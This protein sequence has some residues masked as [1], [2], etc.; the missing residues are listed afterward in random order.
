MSS[1]ETTSIENTKVLAPLAGRRNAPE[2]LRRPRQL[3]GHGWCTGL[4]ASD[5]ARTGEVVQSKWI[6]WRVLLYSA[7]YLICSHTVRWDSSVV[8]SPDSK[9]A[10]SGEKERS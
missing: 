6:K 1:N 7:I 5:G 10:N 2:P 3:T 8:A 9:Q 4:V